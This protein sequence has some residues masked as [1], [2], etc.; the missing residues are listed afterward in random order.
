MIIILGMTSLSH[1]TRVLRNPSVLYDLIEVG[2]P[3]NVAHTSSRGRILDST[4]A[5]APTMY[6]S[7]SIVAIVSMLSSMGPS[8]DAMDRAWD[9]KH[10]MYHWQKQVQL[11]RRFYGT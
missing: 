9:T 7:S 4:T 3:Q 2:T 11:D 10:K 8:I 1:A 5:Q 6:P